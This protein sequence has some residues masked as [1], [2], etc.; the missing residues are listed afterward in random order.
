MKDIIN[1]NTNEQGAGPEVMVTYTV[2]GPFDSQK[3]I[4]SFMIKLLKLSCKSNFF[5]VF[6][7]KIHCNFVLQET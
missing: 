7:S 4:L 5:N 2:Q 1:R 3:D 6:F